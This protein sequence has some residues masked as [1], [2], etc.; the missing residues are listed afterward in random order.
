MPAIYSGCVIIVIAA[1][2]A[3]IKLARNISAGDVGVIA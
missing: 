2:T 3:Y 1:F